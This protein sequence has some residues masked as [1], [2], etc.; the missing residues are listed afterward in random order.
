[1]N[2]AARH[3]L[4]LALA[5]SVVTLV[6]C[7]AI[8]GDSVPQFTCEG[9]SLEACPPGEYCNGSGCKACESQDICDHLD[10][11]CN[12]IVDDGPLSDSDNDGFSWCGTIGSD[13]RPENVDCD[14]TDPTVYPGAPELCDGKDN[15][16]NGKVDDGAK[17]SSPTQSCFN[18]KCVNAC[19][20]DGGNTCG[21]GKHC[22]SVSHTCVSNT[23]VGIG[24]PCTA[25]S[26]CD[27]GYFCADPSVVGGNVV[28]TSGEGMC[29]QTCCTSGNCPTGFV[30]YG[31]GA[32]GRYCVDPTK[33][34]RP[35]SLGSEAP[36]YAETQD[37][38]CRSGKVVS[39]HCA[40]TCCND[41]DCQ[42]STSCAYG[43]MDNKNGFY[44]QSNVGGGQQ[45]DWCTQ[46]TDCQD[47]VCAYYSCY[48]GCCGSSSCATYG[49]ACVYAKYDNSPDLVPLCAQ[50]QLG[51]NG[52]GVPC[53]S[54]SD[55]ASNFCYD[56][57]AK[58]EQYCSDA[59]CVDA[60]CG[61][62]WYCRPSPTTP[63]CVKQ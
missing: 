10:N 55:C 53:T 13:G 2:A 4:A 61:S 27:P 34:G 41:S 14:D 26:E 54:S 63:R 56:D 31:A 57:I 25:D 46:P 5:A 40:D 11:D 30:C 19:D 37:T 7:E 20:V 59:C 1:L 6:S 62:G 3:A 33:L 47:L 15:D 42:G 8:V 32:G 35:S 39:G 9:T 22:D 17:C 23:T 50:N 38:R 12:G 28:P 58:N 48:D 24:Q 44:C 29:T 51:S 21:S 49:L 36:G 16:C 52:L 43:S 18:G 60:D 45:F